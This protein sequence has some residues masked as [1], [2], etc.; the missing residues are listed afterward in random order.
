LMNRLYQ[1]LASGND[2]MTSM[3]QAQLA[4]QKNRRFAHPFFWAPFN[5][6]GHGRLQLRTNVMG[7]KT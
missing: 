1:D 3:Q 6:I 2:L 4:V 7:Q 5:V